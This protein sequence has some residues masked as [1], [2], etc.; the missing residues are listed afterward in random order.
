MPARILDSWP[1]F[2]K[3]ILLRTELDALRLCKRAP[4]EE[5]NVQC[6]VPAQSVVFTGKCSTTFSNQETACNCHRKFA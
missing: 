1:G 2:E 6:S 3:T 5:T 4:D